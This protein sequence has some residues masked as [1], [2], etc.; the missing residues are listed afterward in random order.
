MKKKNHFI[1]RRSFFN[2]SAAGTLGFILS[3]SS[4][5][6][7][8]SA[9][10]SD[11]DKSSVVVVTDENV[12]GS[13]QE[14]ID[15]AV[16]QSMIDAAIRILTGINDLGNAWKTLFPGIT[17]KSIISIKVNCIN[18]RMASHK[19]VAYA[20]AH[21]LTQM[22]FDGMSFAENNIIIWDRKEGELKN[23]GYTLNTSSKGIRCYASNSSCAGYSKKNYNVYGSRQAL[24]RILTD[25]TDFLINLSILKNHGSA[26]VTLSMKNHLGSCDDP[27]KLHPNYCSPYI[28]ALNDKDAI[29]TKQMLCICDALYGIVSG[30]PSGSPQVAPKS[31]IVSRDPVAHDTIGSQILEQFGCRTVHKA[32]HI[33]A[34]ASTGYY[35]GTN[36]PAKIDLLEIKNPSSQIIENPPSEKSRVVSVSD[37]RAVQKKEDQISIREDII[38]VMVDEGICRTMQKTD[39]GE[40]WK[41]LF[42]GLT[43]DSV[44]GIKVNCENNHLSS[45]SEVAMSIVNGLKRMEVNGSGFPEKNI[46]IWDRNESNLTSAGYSLN[47]GGSGVQIYGTDREGVGYSDPPYTVCG[48]SQRLSAILTEK[49]DYLINLSVLSNHEILGAA[50]GMYSQTRSCEYPEL[51][52]ENAGNPGIPAL[53]NLSPIRDKQ[54]ISVCDAVLG[55]ISDGSQGK[56]P[57][58]SRQLLFSRDPVANDWVASEILRNHG[59]NTVDKAAYIET[60]SHIPYNL[61]TNDPEWIELENVINPSLGII[62][63]PP[64]AKS[65]VVK[66]YDE[67]A[68]AG[69][70]NSEQLNAAVIQAM[71][72]AGICRLT[73]MTHVGEAWKSMFPEIT[74]NSIIGIRINCD[75]HPSSHPEVVRAVINGIVQMQVEESPFPEE[76]IIVWASSEADLLA[77]GYTIRK[78]GNGY[79]CYATD[80]SGKGY[81]TSTLTVMNSE[82]KLSRI[83]MDEIDYC[84]N[85]PVLRSHDTAGV[86]LGLMNSLK[87]C[88]NPEALS[89]N[90]YDPGI[91]ELNYLS[92]IREKQVVTLCDAIYGRISAAS[93]NLV[94]PRTL[95]ISRDPVAHDMVASEIL[96]TQGC[97]TTEEA[98]YIDTAAHYPYRLGTNDPDWMRLVEVQNPAGNNG[99][100]TSTVA[101]KDYNG[102]NH[103][104]TFQ[105]YPN[106]PNPF[107]GQTQLMYY[108]PGSQY[109]ELDILDVQGQRVKRLIN[110]IQEQGMH[111]VLWNGRSSRGMAL[112]TG[113]YIA[114][115]RSNGIHQTRKMTLIQ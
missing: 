47:Q 108:L 35:L 69:T 109:V 58:T 43:R 65:T 97:E 96:K 107:N 59:C 90:H 23:A 67:H 25:Q 55:I 52:Y 5:N 45:H 7:L 30:G 100:G 110:R 16:V 111:R 106:Y 14:G 37:D 50:L 68:I 62:E 82:Q 89:G 60:A 17:S 72:D 32:I 20:I 22:Q 81:T 34:A 21:G 87:D 66:V 57:V 104:G 48:Q 64:E 26:G 10:L 28:A 11:G 6:R 98:T 1:S 84:I 70:G 75:N 49:T 105:L 33:A 36:D 94:M 24:S 114:R 38:Q 18:R 44:I 8:F 85:L 79:R 29:K 102:I 46:L 73:G 41:K 63:D 13:N 95:T 76:H 78:Q 19:K 54:V 83:L 27:A 103:P 74:R 80:S 39:V 86:S 71:V 101:Q 12:V 113:T 3:P 51:L 115:I 9:S 2:K 56:I 4:F 93:D 112:P 99:T 91:A 31:L 88:H 53:N 15:S 77:S 92:V 40:A 42:P 61:G